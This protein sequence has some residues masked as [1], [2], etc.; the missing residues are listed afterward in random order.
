MYRATFDD[1]AVAVKLIPGRDLKAFVTELRQLQALHHP[2][3]LHCH[4]GGYCPE[5]GRLF[6]VMELCQRGDLSSLLID[7]TVSIEWPRARLLALQTAEVRAFV[8]MKECTFSLS[9]FF[10]S[11]VSYILIYFSCMYTCDVVSKNICLQQK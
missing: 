1:E 8:H 4:G 2:H 6:F 5:D 11:R 7:H 9:F 10:F 3:I